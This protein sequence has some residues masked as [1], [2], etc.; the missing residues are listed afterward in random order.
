M[1]A[2]T[3]DQSMM[4]DFAALAEAKKARHKENSTKNLATI[5]ASGIPF[6]VGKAEGTIFFRNANEPIVDFYLPSGKWRCDGKMRYGGGNS[7]VNWYHKQCKTMEK[8][9]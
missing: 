4:S 2:T 9:V 3:E 8:N 5:K 7:F 6:T 1:Q